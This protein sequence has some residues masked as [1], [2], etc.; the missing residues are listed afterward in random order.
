MFP[1]KISVRFHR[2]TGTV[3]PIR[4]FLCFQLTL[5]TFPVVVKIG[6]AHSGMGKVRPGPAV[7]WGWGQEGPFQKAGC[8]LFFSLL[9][10]KEKMLWPLWSHECYPNSRL[11]AGRMPTTWEVPVPFAANVAPEPWEGKLKCRDL[12]GRRGTHVCIW[13]EIFWWVW[14]LRALMTLSVYVS[15]PFSLSALFQH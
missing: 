11:S 5:P 2:D 8:T 9:L 13:K 12:L 6:H 15:L 3:W 4:S 7:L 14:R 1:R 10:S